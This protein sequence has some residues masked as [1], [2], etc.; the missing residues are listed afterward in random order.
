MCIVRE[1]ARGV[2]ERE[3][4]KNKQTKKV[5]IDALFLLDALQLLRSIVAFDRFALND[6]GRIAALD[7]R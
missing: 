7:A 1:R 5:Q 2:C 3:K 4:V 6:D